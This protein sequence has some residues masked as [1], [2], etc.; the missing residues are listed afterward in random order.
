MRTATGGVLAVGHF[1]ATHVAII[2]SYPLYRRRDSIM[3]GRRPGLR[4]WE[5]GSTIPKAWLNADARRGPLLS[6]NSR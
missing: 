3:M 2:D 5:G 4:G 1:V 6:S